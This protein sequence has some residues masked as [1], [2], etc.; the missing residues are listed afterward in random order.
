MEWT[1]V[2]S[3]SRTPFLYSAPR[4]LVFSRTRIGAPDWR[5]ILSRATLLES[6]LLS[7]HESISSGMDLLDV[8]S[9][10]LYGLTFL[11]L[12]WDGV[13]VELRGGEI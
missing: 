3:H 7:L 12:S 2:T 4:S 13:V 10:V 11:L 1:W 9:L 8:E 5:F 6:F